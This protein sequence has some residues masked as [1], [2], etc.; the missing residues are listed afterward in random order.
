MHLWLILYPKLE[1][2]SIGAARHN[3]CC[4]N[5]F[6]YQWPCIKTSLVQGP[7]RIQTSLVFQKDHICTDDLAMEPRIT[8][9][10]SLVSIDQTQHSGELAAVDRAD[11]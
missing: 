3:Y 6:V 8:V 4:I 5:H 2:R 9:F 1:S 10:A 7:R 11:D